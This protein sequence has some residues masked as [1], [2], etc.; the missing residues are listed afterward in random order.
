MNKILEFI[1][2]IEQHFEIQEKAIML[3]GKVVLHEGKF[4]QKRDIKNG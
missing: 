3:D 1:K 4:Q 2:M